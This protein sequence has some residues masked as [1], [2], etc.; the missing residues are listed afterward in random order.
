MSYGSFFLVFGAGLAVLD[1]GVLVFA[2]ISYM[3]AVNGLVT[4]LKA[5]KPEA[6]LLL[7]EQCSAWRKSRFTYPNA[8]V[9]RW[10]TSRL[11]LGIY[12][13]TL[14]DRRYR[15]LLWSAR[16]WLIVCL[17]LFTAGIAAVGWFSR[18]P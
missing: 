12:K 14:Q 8:D 11:V 17:V 13:V 18:T 3:R 4:Y 10:V 2:A 5:E 15:Q 16:K 1:F 6:W 7:L 9:V